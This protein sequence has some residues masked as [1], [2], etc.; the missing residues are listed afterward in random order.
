MTDSQL[1]VLLAKLDYE[2][3]EQSTS[4]KLDVTA[5]ALPGQAEFIQHIM[6]SA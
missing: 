6:Q 5:L 2:V 4:V 1:R 3:V